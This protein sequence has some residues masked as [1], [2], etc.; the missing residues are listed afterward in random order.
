MAEGSGLSGVEARIGLEDVDL[1]RLGMAAMRFIGAIE[2]GEANLLWQAASDL[3]KRTVE[4]DAFIGRLM[5][6]RRPL[7]RGT[8]RRWT[9][10][11]IDQPR[12]GATLAPG[13]YAALE[14][15]VYLGQPA[16][17]FREVVSLRLEDDGVWRLAGYYAV[18]RA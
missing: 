15:S 3:I 8:G 7:G 14:F 9:A 17:P 10:V 13:T 12:N 18:G 11:R 5:E 2:R 16:A 4:R 6:G 1:P